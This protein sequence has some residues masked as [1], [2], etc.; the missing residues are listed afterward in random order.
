M[1]EEIKSISEI[2]KKF[3]SSSNVSSMKSMLSSFTESVK[4]NFGA[5]DDS[6][7][8]NKEE[9][10]SKSESKS[11]T[12]IQ[13]AFE[14]AKKLIESPEEEKAS[15]A[16]Q[17]VPNLSGEEDSHDILVSIYKLLGDKIKR[18]QEKEANEEASAAKAKDYE[19]EKDSQEKSSSGKDPLKELLI[20]PFKNVKKQ[21]EDV[22][23]IFKGI[24]SGFK[25]FATTIGKILPVL[26]NFV[27]GFVK[28]LPMFGALLVE[29]APAL[30]AIAAALGVGHVLKK[31]W[32]GATGEKENGYQETPKGTRSGQEL[33]EKGKP[34]SGTIQTWH[35]VERNANKPMTQE[36][37]WKQRISK[38]VGGESARKGGKLGK[39]SEKPMTQQEFETKL[40]G[41]KASKGLGETVAKYESSG[42]GTSE[43][44]YDTDGGTSYGKY[45]IASNTG[46]FNKFLKHLESTDPEAAK[47]LRESGPANTG[48][49]KGATVDTWKKLAS[50]GRLQKAEK[51]FI[52]QTHYDPAIKKAKELGYNT[53]DPRIQEMVWSGSIQHGKINKVLEMGAGG[54][55]TEDQIKKFYSAR[56][57][58]AKQNVNKKYLPGVLN[59]YKNEEKDVLAMDT[60]KAEESETATKDTAES[61]KSGNTQDKY[62]EAY[63]FLQER[64][65]G[66]K[67]IKNLDADYA[68]NLANF[69][70]DAEK[71]F[72]EKA[73]IQSAFR[74][75]T[76]EA[77][78]S[79]GSV[80]T[81]QKSLYDSAKDKSMVARPYH[82]MH[83]T[84]LATDISLGGRSLG[85]SGTMNKMSEEMQTQ[86]KELA[87]KH[88]LDLPMTPGGKASGVTEW[89]HVEPKDVKRGG[90]SAY[91]LE[92]QAYSDYISGRSIEN[93]AKT[94]TT[95]VAAVY[96]KSL[97]PQ[98][99]QEEA[100][101]LAYNETQLPETSEEEEE[102]EDTTEKVLKEDT[103]SLDQPDKLTTESTGTTEK[104]EA[105]YDTYFEDL[106][107]SLKD[108]SSIMSDVRDSN[109]A[110]AQKETSQ[111]SSETSEDTVSKQSSIEEQNLSNQKSEQL[112][113]LGVTEFQN[114]PSLGIGSDSA[115]INSKYSSD[116]GPQSSPQSF[117]NMGSMIG[118]LGS[119]IPNIMGGMNG[120]G[121]VG[122][123]LRTV[124]ATSP[125]I[126]KPMAGINRVMSSIDLIKGMGQGGIGG[127]A[128]GLYGINGVINGIG[129]IA[130]GLGSSI[131]GGLGSSIGGGLG[132]SIA[133]GLGSIAGG[134]GSIAGGLG[135]SIG[136]GL[137]SIAGGLGS[138]AGGL[139][140]SIGGGLGSIADGLGLI[141]ESPTPSLTSD[142][143][144][145]PMMGETLP[146]LQTDN[147]N[148]D[149]STS[150]QLN[151]QSS[152]TG[153]GSPSGGEMP[154]MGSGGSS[155]GGS[156]KKGN[157]KKGSS[158]GAMG[159]EIGLRNEESILQKA[160]YGIVRIV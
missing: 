87:Q 85:K 129:S 74:A 77:K 137:G 97:T 78:E 17:T 31:M 115:T 47:E 147:S 94:G 52:K 127:I 54:E 92:G 23:S 58:Y 24:V 139:E 107:T 41:E 26:G 33:G 108:M 82:S 151:A 55:S 28:F 79:L 125:T 20:T 142:S 25:T 11:K 51:E 104:I 45:Q 80:G 155:G 68:V 36:E 29:L 160:Q 120:M 62:S 40:G 122:G 66:S 76:K 126:G 109:D 75:P 32:D 60:S 81:D 86:W 106:I 102:Q 153:I 98:P 100:V 35:D 159:V 119:M 1:A 134:L 59:R 128:G 12:P 5:K 19:F 113:K 48:S 7:D 138:I 38:T 56:T 131:G 53:D 91:G 114:M 141:E 57:E 69:M 132:S 18:D 70:K 44:G 34:G 101:K 156:M 148:L 103:N 152:S 89:W 96:D 88:N 145:T 61:Q 73:S 158:S 117:G 121:G 30:L 99:K 22:V 116:I 72:G 21:I 112:S 16:K 105:G 83:D 84:G 14:Y 4:E 6:G 149:T 150:S 71:T 136:G 157:A 90:S 154:S 124:G 37:F 46:T 130:G 50:E 110:M 10:A 42:K 39:S 67:D 15:P 95:S 140:S 144:E 13:T 27:S 146:A 118:G 63:Q 135:S 123:V 9:S 143:V 65:S 2:T 49:T 93:A 3:A 133:G 64:S 8:S 111:Q 43:I